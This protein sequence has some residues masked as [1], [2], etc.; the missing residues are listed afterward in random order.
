MTT[1]SDTPPPVHDDQ[2]PSVDCRLSMV[3]SV[4]KADRIEMPWTGD[5]ELL[6]EDFV[7]QSEQRSAEHNRKSRVWRIFYHIIGAPAVILPVCLAILEP[8][9]QSLGDSV[10][11]S[12]LILSGCLSALTQFLDPSKLSQRHS[13]Y[14][15]RFKGFVNELKVILS[16]QKRYRTAADVTLERAVAHFNFMCTTAPET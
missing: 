2:F 8:H 3:G 4:D 12:G 15:Q 16:K 1:D 13:D 14:D 6:L 9:R 11:V 7:R 10:Y 5:H